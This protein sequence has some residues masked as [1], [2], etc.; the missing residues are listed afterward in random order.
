MAEVDEAAGHMLLVG[1]EGMIPI[2]RR[3]QGDIGHGAQ[4][5]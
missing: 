3:K 2:C 1:P 5:S 4:P